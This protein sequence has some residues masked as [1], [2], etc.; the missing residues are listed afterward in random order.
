M[1]DFRTS[2]HQADH[3][4]PGPQCREHGADE[5]ALYL[6][7]YARVGCA[8]CLPAVLVVNELEGAEKESVHSFSL[9]LR[10]DY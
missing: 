1:A 6:L 7:A 2:L 8:V 3:G 4:V 10:L 9:P 5:V